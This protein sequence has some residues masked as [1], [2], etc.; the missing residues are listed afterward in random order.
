[1]VLPELDLSLPVLMPLLS[2]R[3]HATYAF[4]LA[5]SKHAPLELCV[6]ACCELHQA[7]LMNK[8]EF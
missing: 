6:G 1:M 7:G 4:G 2:G 3:Y 8:G 5:A